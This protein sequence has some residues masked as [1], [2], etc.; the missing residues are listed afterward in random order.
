MRGRIFRWNSAT[1]QFK[2]YDSGEYSAPYM[3]NVS[4]TSYY[5]RFILATEETNLPLMV[6]GRAKGWIK[7]DPNIFYRD[8]AQRVTSL[9]TN[10]FGSYTALTSFIE[11]E[12]F[13]ITTL[14]SKCFSGCTNLS[15]IIYPHTLKN[16]AYGNFFFVNCY[17]LKELPDMTYMNVADYGIGNNGGNGNWAAGCNTIKEIKLAN[18]AKNYYRGCFSN[19]TG[20]REITIPSGATNIHS[21]AFIN[22]KLRKIT[23]HDGGNLVIDSA[24]FYFESGVPHTIICE[25]TVRP[26]LNGGAHSATFQ[27]AQN[28]TIY[29]PAGSDYS[30]WETYQYSGFKTNCRFIPCQRGEDGHL[31]IPEE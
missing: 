10:E 9:A 20:L 19:T 30:H 28:T 13:G 15:D 2:Y 21:Q 12:H 31:I 1:E 16:I 4:G 26:T 7:G 25:R 8:E 23:F 18:S 5:N 11:F 24:S 14:P 6:K 3:S 17:K 27:G 22:D 29:Y